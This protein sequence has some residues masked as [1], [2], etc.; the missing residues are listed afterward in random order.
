MFRYYNMLLCFFVS[1]FSLFCSK[2]DIAVVINNMNL[3]KI[4]N[5]YCDMISVL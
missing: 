2:S 1:L 4:F 5:L 3:V